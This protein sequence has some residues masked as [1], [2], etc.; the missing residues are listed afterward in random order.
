MMLDAALAF[1]TEGIGAP[2]SDAIIIPP[3]QWWQG[4]LF[5][6]GVLGLSPAPWLLGM[7]RDKIAFTTPMRAA[8]E[9]RVAEIKGAH[10]RELA[11][12]DRHH[13]AELETRRE[14]Y[15]ELAVSR[16][17]YRT[18]RLEEQGRADKASTALAE[19][20][21]ELG[22]LTSQVLRAFDEAAKEPAP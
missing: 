10:E 12:R 11:E 20:T 19:A 21:A 5:V 4:I 2:A 17:Y 7:A 9:A 6:V 16:D 3:V 14:A 22:R 1:Y 8:V 15:A 18:A 13:A